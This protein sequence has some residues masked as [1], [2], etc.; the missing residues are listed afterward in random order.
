MRWRR[1]SEVNSSSSR[2]EV[3]LVL[4][5]LGWERERARGGWVREGVEER[6]ESGGC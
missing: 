1:D 5:V 3:L 4:V 2:S 6:E